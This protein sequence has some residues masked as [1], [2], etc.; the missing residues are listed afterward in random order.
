EDYNDG[1]A[2]CTQRGKFF[3]GQEL[4]ALTPAGKLFSFTPAFLW[5]KDNEEIESTPHAMMEFK[6]PCDEEL[7]QYTLLRR[8]A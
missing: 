4:E 7:P 8:K 2:T 3:L 6:I 5:D 1:I